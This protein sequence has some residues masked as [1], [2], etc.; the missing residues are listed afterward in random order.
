MRAWRNRPLLRSLGLPNLPTT[1]T[2]L[3]LLCDTAPRFSGPW[4]QR[5]FT[6]QDFERCA[7]LVHVVMTVVVPRLYSSQTMRLQMTANLAVDVTRCEKCLDRGLSAKANS[8]WR[9]IADDGVRPAGQSA[10]TDGLLPPVVEIAN[11]PPLFAIANAWHASA[12]NGTW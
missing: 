10:H 7:L 5:K 12:S 1:R 3:T 2:V 11:A 6:P 4:F 9:R 8:F